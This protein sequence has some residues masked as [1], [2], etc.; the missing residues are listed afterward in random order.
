MNNEILWYEQ[1]AEDYVYAMPIGNGRQGAMIKGGIENER[2][3]LNEDTLWSGFPRTNRKDNAYERYTKRIRDKILR[4][5]DFYGAEDL[6]DKLQGPYNESY[7]SAGELI[8]NFS[9]NKKAENYRRTLDIR[10]GIVYV[11]YSV[12][13]INFKREYF[14]S[15]VD[16]IIVLRITSDKKN[17]INFN[18]TLDSL[19]RHNKNGK[20]SWF[21]LEG[22]APRHIEPQYLERDFGNPQAIIYDEN[23]EDKKGLKFA[24]LLH[25][26]NVGGKLNI[27]DDGFSVTDAD[28]CIIYLYTGTNY[29]PNRFKDNYSGYLYCVKN[30][31]IK[32]K[33][34]NSI[35][36]ALK[37]GYT[38]LKSR[39]IEDMKKYF[40]RVQLNLPINNN[41]ADIPTDQRKLRYE[42][43][44]ADCGF[45]ELLF[46]FGRYLLYSSSREGTQ[47]ANLQGIW[48][49]QLRPNW[50]SNYTININT[51]M[52]YWCANVLN[53]PECHIPLITM[54][55][56]LTHTGE[57]T[58]LSLY[59]A[60]GFCAHHNV[61]IWRSACPIG[62]GETDCKWSLF[63]SGGIWLS[64]HVFEHYRFT[65]DKVFLKKYFHILKKSAL[66][67]IDMM[68][69]MENG[70]L[71][72][73]PTTVP[74]R[75]FIQKNGD[76]FS[77]GVG[78]TFDYELLSELY[79]AIRIAVNELSLDEK[80]LIAEIDEVEK[81][82]PSIPITDDGLIGFWQIPTKPEDY[83]WINT[84]FGLY[85]G[86]SL[87]NS[88]PELRSAMERSLEVYEYKAGAFSN[89]WFAGA[90]ARLGN[91]EKTYDFIKYH[92][93]NAFV[94]SLLGINRN[95]GGNIFQIDSNLGLIAAMAEMLIFSYENSINLLPALPKQWSCGSLKNF[96]TR[97]G[98]SVNAVWKNGEITSLSLFCEDE[99]TVKI[100]LGNS[101]DCLIVSLKSG[102]NDIIIKGEL[103]YE[104]K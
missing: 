23:W 77:V 100:A 9:H 52:N 58:A 82:F 43:G 25:I 11:T 60:R 67:S 19:I 78:S 95:G 71:G 45:E 2:I 92:I 3:N 21:T 24:T 68:C 91:A 12:D 74:E 84:L 42:Q 90:W 81:R 31:N 48:C 96:K 88:P 38:E 65:G 8:L 18:G 54:I 63:T 53:M 10:K 104:Y 51:Q 69:E 97:C 101:T 57:E 79:K 61:D 37:T 7:I 32:E 40:E 83:M 102:L 89:A 50:S 70:K 76:S 46:N 14:C 62:M 39:H 73:C 87:L 41:L 27:N 94:Y 56:E 59:G 30:L 85:P 13:D 28:E 34:K 16:D 66:F 5:N 80:E 29:N 4:Q 26:S 103:N 99:K 49:W 33:A 35:M 98:C 1:P 55:D 15:A 20:D 17:S 22:R 36:S 93:N 44:E 64:L 72:M 75:R 47:A 6:A 86:H